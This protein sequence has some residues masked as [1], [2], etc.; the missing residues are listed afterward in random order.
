MGREGF[1]VLT[2]M[3]KEGA[4]KY[5]QGQADLGLIKWVTLGKSSWTFDPQFPHVKKKVIR[6]L[7]HKVK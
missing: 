7:L 6:N 4:V 5:G 3:A 1:A 2:Q